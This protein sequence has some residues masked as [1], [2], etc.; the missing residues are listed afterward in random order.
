MLKCAEMLV[1]NIC[2]LTHHQYMD[3][4]GEGAKG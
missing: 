1:I 3:E 2:T 4:L